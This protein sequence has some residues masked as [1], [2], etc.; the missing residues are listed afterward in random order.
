MDNLEDFLAAPTEEKLE[1]LTK[2][3]L[4]NASEHFGIELALPKSAKLRQLCKAV[5]EKIVER[6]VLTLG[7][8][9]DVEEGV[10]KGASTLL[11]AEV[12]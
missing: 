7:T 8:Q 2:N 6:M 4:C 12:R 3:Q 5:K 11:M 10:P 1:G 9:S